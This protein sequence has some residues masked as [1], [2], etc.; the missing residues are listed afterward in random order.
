LELVTLELASVLMYCLKQLIIL[1]QLL[2]LQLNQE[3]THQSH[4]EKT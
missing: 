3:H 4:L 1:M 2:V